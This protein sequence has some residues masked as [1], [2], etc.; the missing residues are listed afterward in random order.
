MSFL[1]SSFFLFFVLFSILYF[2]EQHR[3]FNTK[4]NQIILLCASLL[5][6]SFAH[7]GFI[8]FLFYAFL[9][10]YC[11]SFL[12]RKNKFYFITAIVLDVLPLFVFKYINFLFP[13]IAVDFTLLLPLGISF[14]TFQSLSYLI[15]IRTGK[16]ELEKNAI[17]VFLFIC[18]FRQ[19]QADRFRGRKILFRN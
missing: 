5:F 12:V 17:T 8:P 9:I 7:I 10:T 14:F 11:F 4:L 2:L 19:F 16:I 6:Y 1:S 3:F 15:D 18:F 13:F